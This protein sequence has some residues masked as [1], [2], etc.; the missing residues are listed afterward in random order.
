MSLER[1]VSLYSP[2]PREYSHAATSSLSQLSA[3]ATD[4]DTRTRAHRQTSAKKHTY[5][6]TKRKHTDT[7]SSHSRRGCWGEDGHIIMDGMELMEWYQTHGINVFDTVQS[8]P[9]Q[10]LL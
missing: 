6:Y 3:I 8:I 7:E 10:L 4:T 2:N 9:F 1:K 5:R